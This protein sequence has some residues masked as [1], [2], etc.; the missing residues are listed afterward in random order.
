MKLAIFRKY[1]RKTVT[2]FRVK[3]TECHFCTR[4]ICSCRYD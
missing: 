2:I 1:S 4:V 3:A